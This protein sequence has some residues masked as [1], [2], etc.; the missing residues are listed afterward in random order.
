MAKFRLTNS[1]FEAEYPSTLGG[2]VD[3]FPVYEVDNH[4]YAGVDYQTDSQI[5]FKFDGGIEVPIWVDDI[6][7]FTLGSSTYIRDVDF[8]TNDE[9]HGL[10]VDYT[11]TLLAQV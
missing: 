10:V 9:L 5:K 4:K 6:D 7:E 3:M 2:V 11:K 1:L 8:D